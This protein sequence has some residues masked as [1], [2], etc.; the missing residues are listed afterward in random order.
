MSNFNPFYIPSREPGK[1][2]RVY[3][4]KPSGRSGYVGAVEGEEK[5][6]FFTTLLMTDRKL[7]VGIPGRATLRAVVEAGQELL[8]QMADNGYITADAVDEN[9]PKLVK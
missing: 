1:T 2:W 6:G 5:D 9:I 8:R 7:T 3:F 4:F